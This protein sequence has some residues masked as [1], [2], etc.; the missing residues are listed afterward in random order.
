MRGLFFLW[1]L[2]KS[3]PTAFAKSFITRLT[4]RVL[5]DLLFGNKSPEP[6]LPDHV[7]IGLQRVPVVSVRHPRARRYRL[8]LQPD[9]TA[10]VTIPRGGSLHVAAEFLQ[11][12]L[13]WL[14]QQ[15]QKLA[16]QPRPAGVWQIGT[17]IFLRGERVRIEAGESG[18]VNVG[19]EVVTV[20]DSA[21]DLRAPIERHLRRLATRELPLRLLAYASAHGFTVRRVTVRDQ[22]T[23]W[24]SCSR[25][26][27]ISLNWRLIQAPA[28]VQDYLCLHELAHLRHMNHS[29]RFWQEVAQLCPDFEVAERW[30]KQHGAWL[31]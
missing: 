6:A 17:E 14:E 31:R 27:T 12:H 24:G 1:L 13:P 28:F 9:G 16:A 3:P 25:R 2:A 21:A 4:A 11:R 5:L 19:N 15:L 30:L 26:G 10:R 18:Q 23:R 22:R 20:G 7:L 8:R 29:A